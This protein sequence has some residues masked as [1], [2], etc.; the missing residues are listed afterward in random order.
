MSLLYL[1][2]RYILGVEEVWPKLVV[3]QRTDLKSEARN[4]SVL[5]TASARQAPRSVCAHET[6]KHSDR[7]GDGMTEG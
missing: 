3:F 4:C 6:T 7:R 5:G 1:I 2:P